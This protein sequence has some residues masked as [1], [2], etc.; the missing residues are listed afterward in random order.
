MCAFLLSCD[1]DELLEQLNSLV[2]RHA[3]EHL[4]HDPLLDLVTA[5]EQDRERGRVPGAR[6]TAEG[7]VHQLLLHVEGGESVS[8]RHQD[9]WENAPKNEVPCS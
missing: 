1:L 4:G 6:S 7:V 3:H 2:E 8:E 5:L 9:F